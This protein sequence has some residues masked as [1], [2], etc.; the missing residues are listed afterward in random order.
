MIKNSLLLLVSTLIT[1]I[2]VEI[3]LRLFL[4]HVL[5]TGK[6]SR[7]LYYSTPLFSEA[8]NGAIHYVPNVPLKSLAIY[9]N[10][11]EY[12]TKHHTNNLGFISDKN[13]TMEAKDGILFLG[14]S[15]TAGVGSSKPWLPM[16]DEKYPDINLYSFG[17][18]GTG[19]KNFY[20]LF[21]NYQDDLNYS[22]VVIVSIS[23][24]LKRPLWYPLA[25]GDGLFFC[26]ENS[27]EKECTTR[28]LPIMSLIDYD[29][30]EDSLL[31]PEEL[32][33]KKAYKVLKDRYMAYKKSKMEQ[34]EKENKPTVKA[35]RHVVET[36]KKSPPKP[37][38][39]IEYIAKIK[40]LA[41]K[42]GKKV[43]FIHMPEKNE[44]FT[45][46]YR[47]HIGQRIKD[48]GIEYHPILRDY[49]FDKSMF[50]T[51]DGHPNDK[52]YEYI[53]SIVEDILK[54]QLQ[55]PE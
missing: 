28:R 3:I 47:Y 35:E 40:E 49:K 36:V 39:G 17:V 10:T 22:T 19:Q 21:E 27:T 20:K 32:Y 18:T 41:D 53:S 26:Y 2:V 13:Y 24:D 16:L 1:L 12:E 7:S 38:I 37:A 30:D 51:H 50:Y 5:Y 43:I 14:D 48:I 29:T 8:Q 11:I 54:K 46:N 34:E 42:K 45:G 44:T 6:S 23:D 31:L 52:G 4:G 33:L 55:R 15:F 25:V 9:Y